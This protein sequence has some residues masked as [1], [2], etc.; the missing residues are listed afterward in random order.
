MVKRCYVDDELYSDFCLLS[1]I[2]PPFFNIR[3]ELLK[4][5]V[6]LDLFAI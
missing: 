3:T 6:T 4:T 2:G 1:P 5:G